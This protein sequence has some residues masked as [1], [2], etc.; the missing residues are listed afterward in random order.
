[1]VLAGVALAQAQ[2]SDVH[3]GFRFVAAGKVLDAGNYSVDVASNGNVE[4]T[5]EG[6][7]A[8]V[9]IPQ[10]KT[11]SHRNV[12]KPEL[13]FDKVGSLMILSEVWLPETVSGSKI[14]K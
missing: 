12:Q 3:I 10:L 13:V 5:R 7:G 9:E 8:A 4:L 11:L 14:K 2:A 1:M 6:G